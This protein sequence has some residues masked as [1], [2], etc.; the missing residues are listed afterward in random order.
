MATN[1]VLSINDLLQVKNATAMQYGIDEINKVVQADLAYYNG[2]VNESLSQF[3]FNTTDNTLLFGS[4]DKIAMIEADELGVAPTKKVSLGTS[5]GLPLKRFVSAIGWTNKY[6]ELAT[7]AE[8]IT[9]Y[10]AARIGYVDAIQKEM[11]KAMYYKTNQTFV[12]SLDTGL[13]LGVK[14]FLNNDGAI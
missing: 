4:N 12:D 6:L 7:P 9:N 3:C 10:L 14:R 1:G 5:I 11:Q 2:F 8:L 13:S